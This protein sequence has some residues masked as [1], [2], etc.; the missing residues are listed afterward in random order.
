MAAVPVHAA[1]GETKWEAAEFLL[2]AIVRA[3]ASR[4]VVATTAIAFARFVLEMSEEDEALCV[5]GV[6]ERLRVAAPA[7]AKLCQGV[8][9][10]AATQLRRN[11]AL[12]SAQLP[13]ADAP[14]LSWRRAQRGPRL[15][16]AAAVRAAVWPAA[17]HEAE[18]SRQNIGRPSGYK[19]A[20]LAGGP[21]AVPP[22]S[23]TSRT[24]EQDDSD[25]QEL[26]ADEKAPQYMEGTSEA[27]YEQPFGLAGGKYGCD[28][29]VQTEWEPES[30]S[31]SAPPPVELPKATGGG[32][33]PARLPKAAGG[34]IIVQAAMGH[35][36]G[37]CSTAPS[38]DRPASQVLAGP[39]PG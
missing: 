32:L 11:V 24:S 10:P 23:W 7:M 36:V 5:P 20:G 17:A 2:G 29:A 26:E 30:G 21:P 12:H 34:G 6:R 37:I 39:C 1:M 27:F 31:C 9:V 16:G 14:L 25:P 18:V 8:E 35:A 15:G 13:K 19:L 22:G 28:A 4:H 3:G 33:P 38:D